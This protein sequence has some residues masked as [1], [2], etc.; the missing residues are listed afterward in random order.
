MGFLIYS[1][2]TSLGLCLG[3]TMA[4]IDMTSVLMTDEQTGFAI[5]SLILFISLVITLTRY[6]HPKK[7]F[8]QWHPKSSKA[9][10]NSAQ[11]T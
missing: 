5:I 4:G 10:T 7:L 9:A 6:G 1:A 11:G 3:Y 8:L 2:M